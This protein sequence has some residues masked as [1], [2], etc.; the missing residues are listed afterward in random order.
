MRPVCCECE[1]KRDPYRPV[2]RLLD[3]TVTLIC[4]RCY[5]AMFLYVDP[6]DDPPGERSFLW[7]PMS[8]E[9]RVLMHRLEP[10]IGR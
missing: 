2:A 5:R 8:Q 1:R 4:R 6:T 7:E 9:D 3:G 10:R